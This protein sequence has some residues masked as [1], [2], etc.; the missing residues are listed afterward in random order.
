VHA[1]DR[2]IVYQWP[3][4]HHTP[5]PPATGVTPSITGDTPARAHDSRTVVTDPCVRAEVYPDSLADNPHYPYVSCDPCHRGDRGTDPTTNHTLG[6][7]GG[8]EG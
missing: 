8:C 6:A 4:A 2:A 5:H 7:P 3:H 1:R